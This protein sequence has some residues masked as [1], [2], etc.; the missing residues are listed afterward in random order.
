MARKT[1]KDGYGSGG[2]ASGQNYDTR[3]ARDDA[4]IIRLLG[5]I[6]TTLKE[7]KGL[8]S[9]PAGAGKRRQAHRPQ[10]ND[11]F[12][13]TLR[14]L[15]RAVLNSMP[16][17]L[18]P[19]LEPLLR[20]Q[21]ARSPSG[22]V[23]ASTVAP[24]PSND[25]S[26]LP[27]E[28]AGIRQDLQSIYHVLL[29]R[30]A[31]AFAPGS[32]PGTPAQLG[33]GGGGGQSPP[34]QPPAGP[35]PQP[36]PR[37]PAGPDGSPA[38]PA[39]AAAS[40]PE[41]EAFPFELLPKVQ[42]LPEGAPAAGLPE[43]ETFPFEMLP[44][45]QILPEGAPAA[46]LPEA[47][48]VPFHELAQVDFPVPAP[49]RQPTLPPAAFP[50]PGGQPTFTPVDF[51]APGTGPQSSFAPP[52]GVNAPSGAARPDAQTFLDLYSVLPAPPERSNYRL[53]A[54]TLGPAAHRPS[55]PDARL[56]DEAFER[57][58][59]FAQKDKTEPMSAGAFAGPAQQ[60][61]ELTAA[62]RELTQEMREA[63][64]RAARRQDSG[65]PAFAASGAQAPSGRGASPFFGGPPDFPSPISAKK[66]DSG[67]S[68]ANILSVVGAIA[69][70]AGS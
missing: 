44:K 35:A 66:D 58:S 13:R 61:E 52:G 45:V 29:D 10:Q 47:E 51:P 4:E 6:A 33:P 54:E 39:G 23:A 62:I 28:L 50:A 60:N 36:A 24:E 42:I 8:P 63:K 65:R 57:L 69:R 34:P 26:Y 15:A 12:N 68:L 19:L 17:L 20:G 18:R 3:D 25:L 9:L 14:G 67:Q 56:S 21:S 16:G 53:M 38:L 2:A 55:T 64:E 46:G 1:K 5:D 22:G 27:G 32:G 59:Q 41:A 30:L 43:A 48:A 70:V 31:K 37:R 40:P 49:G 7:D 11:A